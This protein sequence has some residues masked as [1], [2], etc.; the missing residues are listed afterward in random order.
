MMPLILCH[1]PRTKTCTVRW[2]R[3]HDDPLNL[4]STLHLGETEARTCL[5]VRS[6]ATDPGEW[7]CVTFYHR[8]YCRLWPACLT[9]DKCQKQLWNLT[10]LCSLEH[11]RVRVQEF[12]AAWW[13]PTA[14]A[15]EMLAW[16][17]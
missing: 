12:K 14:L 16:V 4:L 9:T 1:F 11:K 5:S 17:P 10:F 7:P 2:D 3:G 13:S 6:C 15:E 8:C